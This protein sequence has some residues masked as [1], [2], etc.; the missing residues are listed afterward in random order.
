MLW[1]QTK[2][3]EKRFNQLIATVNSVASLAQEIGDISPPG[4]GNASPEYALR[5]LAGRL[6]DAVA[7]ANTAFKP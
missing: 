5:I 6:R 2:D 7:I 4:K 1:Q 3:L